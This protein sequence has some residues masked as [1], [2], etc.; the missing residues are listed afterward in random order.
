MIKAVQRIAAPGQERLDQPW[1]ESWADAKR[2]QWLWERLVA[3]LF[4]EA[5]PLGNT[6]Y[7]FMDKRSYCE[8]HCG[9]H[10]AGF[11][12]GHGAFRIDCQLR[13]DRG[14][15]GRSRAINRSARKFLD[16]NPY[17]PFFEFERPACQRV[18]IEE[19]KFGPGSRMPAWWAL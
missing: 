15:C 14:R 10:F 3:K 2:T 8:G 13:Q 11:N 19:P 17:R 16:N 1:A 12:R 18:G 7:V 5:L 6:F 9:A 4:K